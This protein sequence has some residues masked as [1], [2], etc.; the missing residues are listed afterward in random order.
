MNLLADNAETL[1]LKERHSRLER[2]LGRRLAPLPEPAR[3]PQTVRGHLLDQAQDLYWNEL[4]WENVTAEEAL[5]EGSLTELAFPAFLA[6]VDG[7]L[8]TQPIV[9]VP[10]T[11]GPR[12]DVVGD[13]LG[14]L[15]GRV[16][17]LRRADVSASDDGRQARAELAMTM[18]L[19]DL[20]LYRLYRLEPEEIER[21]EHPAGSHEG[22]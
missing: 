20:V 3:L 16:V 5:D 8:L 12:A 1:V 13:I 17:E 11:T 2:G 6:Y 10:D 19:I 9:A 4:E 15:A 14:F 7:L 21:V 18:Q 22:G